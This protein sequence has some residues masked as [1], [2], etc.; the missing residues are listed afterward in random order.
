MS[1]NNSTTNPSEL[2]LEKIARMSLAD[3]SNIDVLSEGR[4]VLA[5]SIQDM[6]TIVPKLQPHQMLLVLNLLMA[7][8]IPSDLLAGLFESGD[9]TNRNYA[10]RYL[11][12]VGPVTE[13]LVEA[14][15]Q[16]ATN[17]GASKVTSDM[18][19]GLLRGLQRRE[20]A[21]GMP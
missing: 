17:E 2:T 3:A 7:H 8:E 11:E 6:S 12:L 16:V 10:L 14:I 9:E 13:R 1:S 15:I 5:A 4:S 18:L 20:R 21:G 19:V